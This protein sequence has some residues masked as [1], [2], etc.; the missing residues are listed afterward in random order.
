MKVVPVIITAVLIAIT[1]SS[2]YNDKKELLYGTGADNSTCTEAAGTVSYTKNIQPLLQQSCYS[3]HNAASASGGITMGSF[4]TDKAIAENG[5]LYGSVNHSAG[6]SPMPKG[7]PKLSSCQ[8][9][10]IKKWIDAGIANN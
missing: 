8:L 4:D 2:C 5:K 1:I 10:I 3:C 9:S 7:A 6:F